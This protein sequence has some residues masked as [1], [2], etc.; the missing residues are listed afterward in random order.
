MERFIAPLPSR[1]LADPRL[2]HGLRMF[3]DRLTGEAMS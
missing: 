1:K 2:L 3:L